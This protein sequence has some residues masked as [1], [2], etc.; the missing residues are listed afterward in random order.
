M[1]RARDNERAMADL[2][3]IAV[4]ALAALFALSVTAADEL[5]VT[6]GS[7]YKKEGRRRVLAPV[8][9]QV[10]VAGNAVL[11]NVQ[12]ITT[13]AGGEALLL[14]DVTAAGF[15][16]FHN[17]ATNTIIDVGTY[18]RT[19]TN[20]VT[21]LRLLPTERTATFLATTNLRAIAYTNTDARLDYVIMD[22]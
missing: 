8:G 20:L 19:G 5:L 22:R 18:D 13:N 15:A 1:Q 10:D 9:D 12:T 17:L 11:G 21:F 3:C 2:I 4:I 6:A 16:W 7:Q 14:G